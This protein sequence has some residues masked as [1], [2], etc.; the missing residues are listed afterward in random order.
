[1]PEAFEDADGFDPQRFSADRIKSLHP[2]AY[3]AFGGGRHKCLGNAFARLQIKAI[4]A[5]LLRRY[6]FSSTSDPIG[7]DFHGLVI[8]PSQPCRIRYRRRQPQATRRSAGQA[9]PLPVISAKPFRVVCDLDLCQSH[10]ACMG[11]APEV[12]RVGRVGKVSLIQEYP[13]PELR[14]QVEAA[15]KNCPTGTLRIEEMPTDAETSSG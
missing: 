3:I 12:F 1:M 11:E 13:S 2:F 5:T 10:A 7:S 14:T 15:V 4:L 6:E 9:E 8:G